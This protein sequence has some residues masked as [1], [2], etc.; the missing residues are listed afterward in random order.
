MSSLNQLKAPR[1]A[2]KVRKRVGRAAGQARALQ[3]LEIDD[4]A[5]RQAREVGH[6]DLL[7][8]EPEGVGEPELREAALQRHLPALE[9]LE[10][11]VARAGLLA[12]GAAARRLAL[13]G[14]LAAT[15]A[16]L[17]LDTAARRRLQIRQLVHRRLRA[18]PLDPLAR[19]KA[20]TLNVE[21]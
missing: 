12:L 16:L 9:A 8:L 19:G 10:V 21:Y 15:D 17:L 2:T 14:G 4:A 1:G 20:P 5:G 7:E 11:H 13:P 6:L 3:G 18:D